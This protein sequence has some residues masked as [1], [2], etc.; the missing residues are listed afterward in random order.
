MRIC[1][2]L[3]F[4]SELL[5]EFLFLFVKLRD[6]RWVVS[7]LDISLKEIQGWARLFILYK[8]I[9][10]RFCG[11]LIDRAS[12]V[13]PDLHLIALSGHAVFGHAVSCHAIS[14]HATIGRAFF[15]LPSLIKIFVNCN[16]QWFSI[17]NK[18]LCLHIRQIVVLKHTSHVVHKHPSHVVHCHLSIT[19]C[20]LC[21][22]SCYSIHH[23]SC[24]CIHHTSCSN[25]V[26]YLVMSKWSCSLWQLSIR[27]GKCSGSDSMALA[28]ARWLW[29]WL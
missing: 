5:L 20:Y 17:H 26:Q 4:S 21:Q 29:L 2:S 1:R 12:Y 9:A 7:S 18:L 8:Y 23:M 25:S 28:L 15:V 27:K 16:F 13:C 19:N 3:F 11:S 10:Y 24:I 22:F 6:S 14:G